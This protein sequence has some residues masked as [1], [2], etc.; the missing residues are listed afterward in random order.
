MLFSGFCVAFGCGVTWLFGVAF[1]DAVAFGFVSLWGEADGFGFLPRLTVSS[2]V[3]ICPLEK[4][5]PSTTLWEI[6]RPFL[7][8][9]LYT[10][11][12]S[13]YMV[14]SSFFRT[15]FAC[16]SGSPESSGIDRGTVSAEAFGGM[17]DACGE[18][19]SKAGLSVGIGWDFTAGMIKDMHAIRN[20]SR[21]IN[22]GIFRR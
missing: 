16:F 22:S 6:T 4:S 2:M 14:S 18:A 7:M 17:L 8:L 20:R 21:E 3:E 5:V 1:G 13:I 19:V 12:V 9:L 10:L 11:L 15:C